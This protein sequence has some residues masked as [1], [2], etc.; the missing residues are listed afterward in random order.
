[1]T[2]H[3]FIPEHVTAKCERPRDSRLERFIA[4]ES[5]RLYT[6]GSMGRTTSGF[7][8]RSFLWGGLALAGLGLLSGCGLP[9]LPGQQAAKVPRIGV[10]AVGSREGRAFL[11]DGFLQGLHELGYVEDQNIHIE[12]RYSDDRDDRLPEL[13]ADL[14]TLPVDLIM[15]S[16]T[17]ACAAAKQA[18][19]TTPVVTGW[20]AAHPI[21]TG[22]VA[23]LAHPGGNFTGMTSLAAE[24]GGK[25]L[26]MLKELLPGLAR[27]AV[28]WNPPV[29]TY[30]PIL[31][32]LEA[33]AP[34][35]GLDIQRLEVRV[36]EDFE[37]A[38]AAA[39]R[40]HA[41]VL[42]APGDPLTTNRLKMM[43]ELS[44]KHRLPVMMEQK[45]FPA[46]GGLVAFGAD[47]PDSYRR[48][49]T[50]VDKILKGANPADLP[51]QQPTKF[52]FVINLTT[53]RA[54]G[55]AIPQEVLM[56]ATE[57]IE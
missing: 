30:G 56:Q 24:I 27:V 21:E 41:G 17:P 2:G 6:R 52:D 7:G 38:F 4:A 29:V 33:A 51:M 54:L 23:S 26:E 13:A 47:V 14:V 53:A 34:R 46:A 15:C 28:F 10:L 32:E 12:Y 9:S 40:E 22:F 50:Y 36:P 31:K 25:R 19:S 35:L 5:G 20:L 42:Y 43:A 16:G 11:I 39:T 57:V 49:A 8:R 48:S 44:L 37:E 55:L 45:E 1:M 18:T 3:F